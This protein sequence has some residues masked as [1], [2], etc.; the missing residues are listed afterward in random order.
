MGVKF[1]IPKTKFKIILN[2]QIL[3]NSSLNISARVILDAIEDPMS[4][5]MRGEEN[6]NYKYKIPNKIQS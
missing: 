5:N 4:Q 1:Q 6:Q 2:L 3:S